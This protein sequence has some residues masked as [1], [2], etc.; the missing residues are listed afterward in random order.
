MHQL[1][2]LAHAHGALVIALVNPISLATLAPP[3]EWGQAGCDLA[4]GNGQP[5]G[6]P[7]SAG[8]PS[9]GFL[10]ATK[11]LLRQMPGRIVGKTI[12]TQGKEG[13][14]LTLQAREQH[15]RRSKATSNICT[16]Q[17]LAVIASTIYL[18]LMGETGLDATFKKS[19]QALQSLLSA[20]ATIKGF[21]FPLDNNNGN[22]Y[23]YE[24]LVQLPQNCPLTARQFLRSMAQQG[25]LAGLLPLKE[26]LPALLPMVGRD[27]IAKC[28][29]VAATEK[30]T[31]QEINAYLAAA[32][33]IIKQS[34]KK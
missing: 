26:S 2:D 8:G 33:K 19:R 5:L 18:A 22:A 29:I 12:D 32:R 21:S 27:A 1:T 13:F 4:C 17:G 25:I 7:L 23:G 15:I 34:Y 20:L 9:Y 31:D 6:I 30:R 3:G 11:S 14:V 24:A 10:C 28:F 16:N